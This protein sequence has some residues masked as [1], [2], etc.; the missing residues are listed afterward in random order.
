MLSRFGIFEKNLISLI[1]K[2]ESIGWQPALSGLENDPVEIFELDGKYYVGEGFH[3]ILLAK[4]LG[5][6]NIRVII[7]KTELKNM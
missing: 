4:A 6:K 7:K 2:V 5:V 3:R 1:D